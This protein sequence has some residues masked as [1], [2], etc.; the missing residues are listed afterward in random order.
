[1]SGREEPD[2]NPVV[3]GNGFRITVGE[4]CL[5]KVC[6]K[7]EIAVS[8]CR[9]TFSG[10]SAVRLAHLLWEQ[11]VPGSNP[12][13]PT[14]GGGS[15]E[16]DGPPP[17]VLSAFACIRGSDRPSRSSSFPPIF[18]F[19][20]I[21]YRSSLLPFPLFFPF[22]RTDRLYGGRFVS[23]GSVP[24]SVGTDARNSSSWTVREPFVEKNGIRAAFGLDTR[25][26]SVNFEHGCRRNSRNRCPSSGQGEYVRGSVADMDVRR[27][28]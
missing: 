6:K 26:E 5:K 28:K 13:T 16:N 8:S 20:S 19:S 2:L 25:T 11:G 17:S 10:C 1:M 24:M 12:G 22:C 9:G 27:S 3:P 7:T 14:R 4:L 21:F 18:D 15:S 23:A